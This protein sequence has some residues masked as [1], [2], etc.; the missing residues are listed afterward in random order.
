[1]QRVK[2]M[3]ILKVYSLHVIL[4]YKRHHLELVPTVRVI[5]LIS[6]ALHCM[7]HVLHYIKNLVLL[8]TGG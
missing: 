1:M 8:P 6:I 4:I 5:L 3:K 2:L 7:C